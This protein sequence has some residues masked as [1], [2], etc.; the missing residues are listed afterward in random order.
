MSQFQTEPPVVTEDN[1]PMG[2]VKLNHPAY[3]KIGAYRVQGHATLYGSEFNHQHY[4]KVVIKRSEFNAG[5]YAPN[6]GDDVTISVALE[7]VKQ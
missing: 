4:V 2:G 6:V 3:A 5:K 7:A 1:S